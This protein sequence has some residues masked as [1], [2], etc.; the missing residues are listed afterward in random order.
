MSART[1]HYANK[2]PEVVAVATKEIDHCSNCFNFLRTIG[3]HI[4]EHGEREVR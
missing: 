2:I 3:R 1:S 4:G